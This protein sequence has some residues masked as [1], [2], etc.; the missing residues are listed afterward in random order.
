MMN[1]LVPR[2]R[3]TADVPA[4]RFRVF[5]PKG[6]AP[7]VGDVVDLDQEFTGPDGLAMVLIYFRDPAVGDLYEAEVYESEL[8]ESI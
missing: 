8:S 1:K 7:R 2:A 3:L 4:D 6:R 5:L